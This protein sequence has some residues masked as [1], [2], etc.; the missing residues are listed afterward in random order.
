MTVVQQGHVFAAAV[1]CGL[2]IGAA[3]DLLGVL[4]RG[5]AMTAAADLLLGTAAAIGII[6]VG[7][8]FGCSPFR[9][10]IFAGAAL[11]WGIYGA[12]MGVSARFCRRSA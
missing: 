12:M 3:H 10:H 7:L 4:R 5:T 1:L 6:S 11:G 2:C 9:L 8:H